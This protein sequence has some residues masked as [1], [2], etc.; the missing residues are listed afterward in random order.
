[1]DLICSLYS[2]WEGF[3]SS[4]LASLRLGFSCGFI[5]TSASGPSTW[6]CSWD[7][8]GGLGFG[9]VRPGVEAVQ[10]LGSQGFWQHQ[11]L[12][13]V[14]GQGRRK[15]SGLNG[16]GNWYWL[17]CT[18]SLAWRTPSLTEAWQA[19]VYRTAKSQTWL[20]GPCAHRRKTFYACGSSAPARVEREGDAAAWLAGTLAASM[21]RDMDFLHCRRYGPIGL[22]L[23]LL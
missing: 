1:M 19:T 20:K 3:A 10:M 5:S 23:S 2:W 22:F 16:Y 21:C 15:Y 13:G 9:P 7:C 14:S 8:P 18:S 6:V 11:V 17:I 4:S 12:R